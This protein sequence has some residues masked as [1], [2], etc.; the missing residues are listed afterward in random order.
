MTEEVV[1]FGD[2]RRLVGVLH[3]PDHDREPD[4]L[5]AVLLLNAGILHRVGPNRLYVRI[6]RQLQR[7]GFHV[8]RFDVW[9]IGDSQEH[10]GP[11]C[12]GDFFDDTQQA[13]AMLGR[14][15]GARRFMLIGICMGAKIALEVAGRDPRVESMVLMEGIYI[16][17]ARYHLTRI[18]SPAKWKRVF[19]GQSYMVKKLRRVMG[20]GGGPAPAT[21]P[22]D[23]QPSNPVRLL[24]SASAKD[25]GTQLRSLLHRGVKAMLIFRD[26]N[27]IRYNY[28]LRRQGDEIRAIGLPPGLEVAFIPFADH[29]FTPLVSQNL[30]LETTLRWVSA[31]LPAQR[32]DPAGATV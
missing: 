15:I 26:G 4:D 14:R 22:T 3:S 32:L 28:R 18:F 30:L 19:S 2:G 29:T 23:A 6:A 17:S 12:S 31:T 1:V 21:R 7:L 8:L 25:M 24:D 10:D 20:Q 9:G 27:E 11:S 5:P 16:K 13:M